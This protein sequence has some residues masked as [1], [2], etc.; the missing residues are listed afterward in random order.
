[1]QIHHLDDD[2]ARGDTLT[3]PGTFEPTMMLDATLDVLTSSPVPVKDLA[4]VHVHVGTAQVLARV[5][6]LGGGKA[7]APGESGLVQLR[8]ESPVVAARADRFIVR[9]YSPLETIA[10]GVVLDAHPQKHAVGSVDAAA[11]VETL[12][13]GD[14]ASA[15]VQ[16]VA[17][18]G[19]SGIDEAALSRRLGVDEL[20]DVA[21]NLLADGGPAVTPLGGSRAQN[22]LFT[23]IRDEAILRSLGET[24]ATLHAP[25]AA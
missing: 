10:G 1:M 23:D 12:R 7:L 21:A 3:M 4:R 25:R 22:E 8:L 17:E 15:A 13:D 5:R 19:T 9:R 11:R 18:A 24:A 20:S 14:L 2:V 16:F 6:I